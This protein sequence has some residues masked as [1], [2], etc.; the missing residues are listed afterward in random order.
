MKKY[1]LLL[2]SVAIFSAGA[3][4]QEQ[5]IVLNE[6]DWQ[7]DN[8]QASL[9]SGSTVT[10]AW[11]RQQNSGTKLGDT[12]TDIIQI[13]S[14]LLAIAVNW[15]NIIQFITPEGKSCGATENVPNN[16]KL[17]T[18][19]AYLYVTSY[20]HST[21]LG[22]KYTKGYVAKIDINTKKVVKTCEVGYEPEGIA[23]YN[24]KLFIANTGGYAYSENHDYESSVSIVD[25]ESMTK[26][27]DVDTKCINLYGK[28]SQSDKYLCIN[29]CGDYYDVS[30]KTVIF[31]CDNYTF[32]T[33]D[34]PCT[35]NCAYN[36]KFYTI[37]SSYSY[38]TSGYEY[39]IKTITPSDNTVEDGIVSTTVTDKIKKLNTPYGIY[40]N[41]YT[42]YIYLSDA[43]GY[44]SGGY[45]Y[46]F[47]QS[48]TNLENTFKV[49]INP[50]HF[51][52]LNPSG[53]SSVP[54]ITDN[55]NNYNYYNLKGVR[56]KPA[57]GNIYIYNG[58]KVLK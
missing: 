17:A 49:Y 2:L 8:G 20:A 12:P 13:N 42:G 1:I 27:T 11:F 58:K 43:K 15:S 53:T 54:T 46:Q 33:F 18:D 9:I 57:A 35:Y 37:G 47:N 45:V 44:S 48:G 30:A 25:A 26:L 40:I 10:N 39:S 4:A 31:N 55:D 56:V 32:V 5:V 41:P 7:S 51:L 24:G 29:S 28:M 38:S 36:G 34:F 50:A 16:R 22:E 6:G 52:A 14:N 21:A 3:K 23:Y 19:G